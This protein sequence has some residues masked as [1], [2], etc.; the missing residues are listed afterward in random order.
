MIDVKM[1]NSDLSLPNGWVQ[2]R[3]IDC[4]PIVVPITV[5]CPLPRTKVIAGGAC[6]E[7]DVEIGWQFGVQLTNLGL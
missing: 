4:H 5:L 7:L 1:K 2:K 6:L 3:G